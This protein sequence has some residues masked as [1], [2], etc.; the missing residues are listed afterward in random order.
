ML[1]TFSLIGNTPLVELKSCSYAKGVRLFAKLEMVNPT[2]SVK[3]RIAL[4]MIEEAEK[5][6]VLRPG[7]TLVEP[8]SGNTGA[9]LAYVGV[10]RGYSVKITTPPKTNADKTDLMRMYG[11]EVIVCPGSKSS[12]ADHYIA[13]AK[14]LLDES[15]VMLDQYNNPA[16]IAAHYNG[17]GPEIWSSLE[18]KIDYLVACA[19]SGGT[20]TGAGRYL[21][22]KN[23]NIQVVVP[24]P[25]G[26][27]HFHYFK[28]KQIN[29]NLLKPYLTQ[30]AG[31]DS[32]CGCLDF[33]VIDEMIPF[34]DENMFWGVST[35][36]QKERLFVGETSG[37]AFYAADQLAKKLNKP[38]N[39]VLI[40][41]D[42]GEKYMSVYKENE[43]SKLP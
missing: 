16:N 24:D 14:T 7:M 2:R 20:V 19:S 34:S 27:I 1:A 31:G 12:D 9:S 30:G 40:F 36:L 3:D 37:A 6:G 8:T 35:L 29:L 25:I 26:S 21:K 15:S 39:I 5:K 33:S 23:R 10:S 28:T 32:L 42:S 11:A 43:L 22:S 18:G 13:Y 17:T 38:A 4:Q 41:P